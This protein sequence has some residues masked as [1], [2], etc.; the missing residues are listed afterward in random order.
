MRAKYVSVSPGRQLSERIA[1][2][3]RRQWSKASL[4]KIDL[5]HWQQQKSI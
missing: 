2:K 5:S 3:R 1:S 4:K